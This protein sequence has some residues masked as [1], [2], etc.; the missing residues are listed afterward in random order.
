MA[1]NDNTQYSKWWNKVQIKFGAMKK[2]R[3]N[4]M[5]KFFSGTKLVNFEY[6]DTSKNLNCNRIVK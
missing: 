1:C 6:R 5:D 4:T 2:D 3:K